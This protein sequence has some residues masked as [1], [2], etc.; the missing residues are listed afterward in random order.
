MGDK[1]ETYGTVPLRML[2]GVEKMDGKWKKWGIREGDRVC[3][4]GPKERDRNKIGVVKEIKEKAEV[5]KVT[6][7]NMVYFSSLVFRVAYWPC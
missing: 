5:C 7:L 2:E 3:V 4:V 6:G 1:A